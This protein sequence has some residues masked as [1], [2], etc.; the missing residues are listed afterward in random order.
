MFHE[1]KKNQ[2]EQRGI[3]L[4]ALRKRESLL[5]ALKESAKIEKGTIVTPKT[6]MIGQTISQLGSTIEQVKIAGYKFP[7]TDSRPWQ[8]SP[9]LI[10]NKNIIMFLDIL[11][12]GNFP[13]KGKYR[14]FFMFLNNQ[15]LFCLP[16]KKGVTITDIKKNLIIHAKR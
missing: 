10:H 6:M 7:L 2:F 13:R 11:V 8:I 12:A 9:A 4:I 16:Y 3:K 1:F 15:K 14:L 5:K